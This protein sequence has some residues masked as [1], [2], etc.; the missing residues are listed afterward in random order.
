MA[1]PMAPADWRRAL[2]AEGVRFVELDG[3]TTRGRDQATGKTFGPV[4]GVLNHH[5]A[6]RDS[7]DVIAYRGQGAAVP[8]PLAHALLRKD[9]VVVLVADGRANH[10]G[11]AAKNSFDAIVA[12][13]PIPKPSKA[14]GT[15]DGNDSLYGLET[16]NLGNGTDVY[17]RAQYDAWVRFNAAICRFHGWGAGSCAGHL[18]TSVEGKPDPR[19]PVE[20]YGRRGRFTFTM[21]QLRADVHER[22]AHAPSWSPPTAEEAP[23]MTTPDYVNLGLAHGVQLAPGSWDDVEF[24]T[25]WNDEAND[26]ATDSP[27]FVQGPAGFTGSVSFRFEH[28]APGAVVQVRMSEYDA[29]GE[30]KAN[31]PIH[32]VIGTAGGTYAVVPLTKRVGPGRSMRVRLLNQSDDNIE[33]ASAVLTAW[34]WEG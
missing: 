22:L 6:G 15:V 16:E 10:A 13:K 20:G 11:L 28:L 30:L 34:V 24:T 31:H 8:P 3:W 33:V 26:H 23:S 1:A 12:E 4:N 5:T 9:G 7:L 32:E 25:E 17:T 19:G 2:K 18:E 21:G 14:S 27:T 29:A